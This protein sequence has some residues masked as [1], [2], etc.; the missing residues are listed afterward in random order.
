[1]ALL[2]YW[3]GFLIRSFPFIAIHFNLYRMLRE[4]YGVNLCPSALTLERYDL[5][6]LLSNLPSW[7]MRFSM[8]R[9][10][11]LRWGS[12]AFPSLV[13]FV[14]LCILYLRKKH[15]STTFFRFFQKSFVKSQQSLENT[16]LFH[17]KFFFRKSRF[18]ALEL[19]SFGKLGA[20][21]PVLN[22]C[23]SS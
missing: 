16:G 6:P 7:P 10:I 21:L 3:G 17:K 15:M 14:F 20:L 2:A 12:L 19:P 9:P 18:F 4:L 11:N 1:M 5:R 23:K 8:C 22:W 13:C